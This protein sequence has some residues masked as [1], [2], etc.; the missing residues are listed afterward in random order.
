[1]SVCPRRFELDTFSYL[2]MGR[3]S[4][5]DRKHINIL[6]RHGYSIS[7]IKLKLQQ[8]DV[9]VRIHSLQRLCKN[10]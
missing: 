2:Q 10:F 6:R 8:E 5:L 4:I 7:E 3:L 9:Y 1:M